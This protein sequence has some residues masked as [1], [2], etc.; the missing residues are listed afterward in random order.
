MPLT[1]CAVMG[2]Q[3]AL[4]AGRLAGLGVVQ[5]GGG[6]GGGSKYQIGPCPVSGERRECGERRDTLPGLPLPLPRAPASAHSPRCPTPPRCGSYLIF[7]CS[8][9]V[10][11]QRTGSCHIAHIHIAEWPLTHSARHTSRTFF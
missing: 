7:G 11:A 10:A 6:G 5:G 9:A 3:G 4:G 1:R 8:F 2:G